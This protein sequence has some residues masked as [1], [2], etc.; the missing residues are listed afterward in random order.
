LLDGSASAKHPPAARA[1]SAPRAATL[2]SA[3]TNDPVASR[4][5]N[6]AR[7]RRVADLFRGYMAA[8]GSPEDVV[9]QAS[10]LAAAELKVA[11]ED[12]RKRTLDGAGDADAL[13]RIENLAHRAER[14]LGIKPAN[15]PS[16]PSLAEH[17]A[18]RAA[19]RAGTASG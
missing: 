1:L 13:V 8:L 17:L 2:R 7:G 5:R 16:G 14:K 15:K 3:I 10:I 11:A 19:E 6:T 18:R 4:T 12:A 9:T